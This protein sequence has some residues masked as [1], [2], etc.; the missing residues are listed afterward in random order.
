M[1]ELILYIVLFIALSGLMAMIDAAVL[2]V[3]PA[4]VEV[5]VV[6]KLWGAAD[7]QIVVGKITRAVVVI[8]LITNSINVLGPI[9]AGNKAIE[10]Y[11]N[12]VIGVITA[13]LTLGTIVFSEIIP[14][15]LGTHYAPTIA[16]IAAP[17]IR[18]LTVVLMPLVVAL[19]WVSNLLKSGERP[20]G[21]EPQIRSLVN[22]GRRA[23]LIETDEG[24]LIHRAF[25]LN[26]RTAAHIMTPLENV[27]SL[28]ADETVEQA[29]EKIANQPYSR[30]PVFGK[31]AHEVKGM[32]LSRDILEAVRNQQHSLSVTEIMRPA[33][34][35]DAEQRSD[36]L[37]FFFRDQHVHMAVVQLQ[38]KTVGIVTLE[39]V[40]EELVGEIEDEL[41][42]GVIVQEVKKRG[43]KPAS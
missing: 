7:L 36:E 14:K 18:W 1:I 33:L 27:I 20:I 13:I 24:Q 9:L 19:E 41:D 28:S 30:Y 6:K 22:I 21:T 40:L 3:S 32:V 10:L 26:D 38:E 15:S 4:E 8:V 37:L 17:P 39:D 5:M 11:G 23:G 16:R 35:I 43:E 25:L 12:T 31:T 29:A 2:S 34:T 42:I